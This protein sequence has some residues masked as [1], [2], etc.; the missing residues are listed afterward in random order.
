MKKYN[1]QKVN[2]IIIT[3]HYKDFTKDIRHIFSYLNLKQKY[4]T[5]PTF[6]KRMKEANFR[7]LLMYFIWHN[8]CKISA[9]IKKSSYVYKKSQ[10]E[11]FR[12][13]WQVCLHRKKH[14][15]YQF[16]VPFEG[17]KLVV[18]EVFVWKKT[19]KLWF[20]VAAEVGG[21]E[22]T[23]TTDVELATLVENS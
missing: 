21:D 3:Q 8:I 2:K 9:K 17:I 4:I 12:C 16:P 7:C 19:L 14:S 20:A 22:L 6:M 10:G 13:W 1:W 18:S 11:E 23:C 15:I 5:P